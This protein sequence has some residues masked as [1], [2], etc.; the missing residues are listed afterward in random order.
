MNS[1]IIMWKFKK[2]LTASGEV[3]SD[4]QWEIYIK[5]NIC[6]IK[7]AGKH[8]CMTELKS[9]PF[10]ISLVFKSSPA[11]PY[12]TPPTG[13]WEVI[14]GPSDTATLAPSRPNL[15]SPLRPCCY[16]GINICWFVYLLINGTSA[17]YAIRNEYKFKCLRLTQCVRISK[18]WIIVYVEIGLDLSP[19]STS[20]LDNY[21]ITS[22]LLS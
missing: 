9:I 12:R 20:L 14:K 1:E 8:I 17:L 22:I 13:P 10:T 4:K 3:D 18:G 11:R 5:N 2:H 21:K 16:I 6:C 19:R 7:S 15:T